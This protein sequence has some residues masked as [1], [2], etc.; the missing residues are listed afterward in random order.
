[1]ISSREVDIGVFWDGRIYSLMDSGLGFLGFQRMSSDVL[2][3]GV[4]SQV[5]KGGNEKLALEWVNTL[6]DPEP[7]LKYFKAINYAVT[8]RKVVYPEAVRNRILP[9]ELGLV[10]P[11]RELARI[12]PAMIDRWNKEDSALDR[13]GW[14]NVCAGRENGAPI[15]VARLAGARVPGGRVRPARS[16]DR[17]AGGRASARFSV[18]PK[19]LGLSVFARVFDDSYYLKV[20]W[21]TIALSITVGIVSAVFGYPV[22]YFL[23][24][25]RSR[26]RNAIFYFTLIP[27]AVGI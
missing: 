15:G 27:M 13:Q 1:M 8:N 11:Y 3:S 14:R 6:L 17:P 2:I 5:V 24:R 12:T 4:S 18:D 10:A 23:V 20:L 9:V 26:W 19:L 21:E 25:S 7:Q 16:A 22:A